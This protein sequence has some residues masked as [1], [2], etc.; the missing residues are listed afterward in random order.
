MQET[1][2]CCYSFSYAL[3]VAFLQSECIGGG[4]D[5]ITACD[6][7][8]CTKDA[9]FSVKETQIAMVADLGT[10]PRIT[11]IVSKGVYKEMVNLWFFLLIAQIYTGEPINAQRA[12][13][14]GLVN[15]VYEDKE[16]LLQAARTLCSKIAAN[17][18]LAVQGAKH[19]LQYAEDHTMSDTLDYIGL[20]N[21]SFLESE[22][23]M[24]SVVAFM[25]KRRPVYRN[26]L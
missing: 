1:S 18:P 9:S 26:K 6:I 14:F 24:E 7:R 15:E 23:L 16:A 22:D 4:V 3:Y 20:W 19:I 12:H 13:H 2:S 10:I 11:R 5:L 25:Q 17:S 8:L 21:T